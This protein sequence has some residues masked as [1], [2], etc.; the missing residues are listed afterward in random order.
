MKA[1]VLKLKYPKNPGALLDKQE[2]QTYI[3]HLE[4]VASLINCPY[5]FS[6]TTL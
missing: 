2:V 5:H 6:H 3:W 1:K 4:D